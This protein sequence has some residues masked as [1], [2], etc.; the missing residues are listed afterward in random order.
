M[1]AM[2]TERSTNRIRGFTLT[3]LLI[4]IG[5]V[6]LV[7]LLLPA[8]AAAKQKA[9]RISC[10]SNLKIIGISYRVWEGDHNDKSPMAVSVTNGGAMELA[11]AGNA[12]VCFQV[13]SNLLT[14]PKILHCPADTKRLAATNFATGFSDANISYFFGLDA[15]ETSPQMILDGDDNLTVDGVRVKPGILN[16]WPT[17]SLAW[18][19]ERHYGVGNIG[20]ADGSVQQATTSLLNSAAAAATNGAAIVTLRWVIP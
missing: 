15:V 12:A 18:T 2:K 6:A 3:E 19:K 4:V 16:L 14:T 10:I 17:N 1:G 9:L 5:A 13:M 11:V 8:L 7:A 20:M